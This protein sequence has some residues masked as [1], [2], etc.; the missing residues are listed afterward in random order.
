MYP[1]IRPANAND[2]DV[3]T[4]LIADLNRH[5]GDPT[6]HMTRARVYTDVIGPERCLEALLAEVEG[7][8][9]GYVLYNSSYETAF[10]ARG[11]YVQDLFVV[12]EARDRGVGRALVGA[13]ARRARA[14]GCAFVWWTSKPWNVEAH[15]AYARWGLHTEPVNAHALFGEAFTALADAAEGEGDPPADGDRSGP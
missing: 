12:P 3:L 7:A 14:R 2:L 8:V 13:V 1:V 10:A 4:A 9:L 15:A 5:Q 11:L 6:E